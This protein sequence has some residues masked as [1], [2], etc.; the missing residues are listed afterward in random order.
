[1]SGERFDRTD[2]RELVLRYLLEEVYGPRP[3][4]QDVWDALTEAYRLT[5]ARGAARSG[6]SSRPTARSSKRAPRTRMV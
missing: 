5:A 1:M 4:L 6:A 3:T 2:G